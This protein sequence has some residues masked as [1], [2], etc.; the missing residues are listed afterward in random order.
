MKNNYKP[1]F[2]K[3]GYDTVCDFMESSIWKVPEVEASFSFFN[4]DYPVL[5]IH[6]DYCEILFVY[7]G[8][9]T[10]FINGEKRIMNSGDC[11][12]I[13][14][15]DKHMFE[16]E[17]KEHPDLV[18]INFIIRYDY[19]EKLIQVFGGSFDEDLFGKSCK[20]KLFHL[21]D[22]Q[23]NSIY[24][25]VLGLQ[26]HSNEY[27]KANEFACKKVILDL[28]YHFVNSSLYDMPK[29]KTP[30]WMKQLLE[31]VQ[32]QENFSRKPADILSG[33][34]YSYSY[35]A[36]EFKKYMGCSFVKYFNTIKLN[37]AMDLLL[38]TRYTVIDIST[39]LG[40]N[41]LSHFNHMFKE[42]FGL[43]PSAFRK[44]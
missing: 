10:N 15:D 40:F 12:L 25:K 30:E 17:S 36:R 6:R 28:L 16:F 24:S 43:P 21:N 4:F 42:A 27:L 39:R 8:S 33:I 34:G 35:I 1:S 37:Y 29:P 9:I 32:K 13:H 18:G 20:M 22:T 38:H 41:S 26:T 14:R 3:T 2:V 11:C 23:K 44:D 7:S 31:E 19:Y 5:H